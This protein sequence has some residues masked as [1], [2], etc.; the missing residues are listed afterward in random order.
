MH[1]FSIVSCS[2]E[3]ISFIP[4]VYFCLHSHIGAVP[5]CSPPPHYTFK[6]M[7]IFDIVLIKQ[8]NLHCD[9]LFNQGFLT[10][11]EEFCMVSK[12]VL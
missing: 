11:L 5:Q 3:V 4:D 12:M 8:T 1:S 10:L 6:P 7:T 9:L 2:N